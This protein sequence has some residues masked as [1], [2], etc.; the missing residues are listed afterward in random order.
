MN[1]KLDTVGDGNCVPVARTCM[2]EKGLQERVPDR[3]LGHIRGIVRII[4][5]DHNLR[6]DMLK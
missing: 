1:D 6:L 5:I 3:E 4:S 2:G